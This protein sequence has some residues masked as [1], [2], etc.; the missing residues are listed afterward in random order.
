MKRATKHRGRA[1]TLIEATI[2]LVIVSVMLVAALKTVGASARARRI[3]TFQRRAPALSRQLMSEILPC[4]YQEPDDTPVFGP[5]NTE[6]TATRAAFDDVDDFHGWSACPPQMP[7]GAALPDLAGWRRSVVVEYVDA[8][9]LSTVSSA[10]TGMKRITVTTTDPQGKR[11]TLV[12]L[13]SSYGAYDHAPTQ[14]TTYV[15]WIGV[16]LQ[17]GDNSNLRVVCGAN[18]SNRVP[19]QE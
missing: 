10:D 2:S 13:R 4:R 17:I 6:N 14:E 5:E 15:A 8:D 9:D 16:D 12:A 1:M 19:V 11:T 3:Q 18:P 7:D